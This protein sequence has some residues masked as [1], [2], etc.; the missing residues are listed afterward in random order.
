MEYLPG[1]PLGCALRQSAHHRLPE[2]HCKRILR[3]LAEA[4]KYLH[5]RCIAHRDIKLENVILD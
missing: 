5:E 3:E 2:A 4:L 1:T